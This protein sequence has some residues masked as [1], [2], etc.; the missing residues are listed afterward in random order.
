MASYSYERDI[1]PED[2]I[3]E[4]PPPRRSSVPTGGTT[5]GIMWC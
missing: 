2:L 5:T 1:T 3:Q 4:T